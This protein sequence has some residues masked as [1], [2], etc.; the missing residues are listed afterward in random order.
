M[1][2]LERRDMLLSSTLELFTAAIFLLQSAFAVSAYGKLVV[3]FESAHPFIMNH[4]SPYVDGSSMSS[5]SRISWQDCSLLLHIMM[6]FAA[7]IFNVMNRYSDEWIPHAH[8]TP[9]FNPCSNPCFH[10][11]YSLLLELFPPKTKYRLETL[12]RRV[13]SSAQL[14]IHENRSWI[15]CLKISDFTAFVLVML[16]VCGG[17]IL[18]T[19][20]LPVPDEAGNNIPSISDRFEGYPFGTSVTVAAAGCWEERNAFKKW[21]LNINCTCCTCFIVNTPT[22]VKS[23][24][25]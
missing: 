12:G 21:G 2:S 6:L 9:N 25:F 14:N 20:S 22:A 3:I 23:P 11:H 4:L 10:L 5:L 19:N 1:S 17:H 8:S 24:I 18:D 15:A 13:T 7:S 16:L